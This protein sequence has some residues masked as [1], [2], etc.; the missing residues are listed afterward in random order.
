MVN[1]FLRARNLL[2]ATVT[3]LK[4]MGAHRSFISI[5]GVY[6]LCSNY[7]VKCDFHDKLHKCLIKITFVQTMCHSIFYCLFQALTCAKGSSNQFV[8]YWHS[9]ADLGTLTTPKPANLS[10]SAQ[11]IASFLWKSFGKARRC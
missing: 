2:G 4:S 8:C 10:V 7:L 3:I 1:K 6:Y 5:R 11:K 9:C